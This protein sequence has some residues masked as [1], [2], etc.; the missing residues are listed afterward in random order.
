MKEIRLNQGDLAYVQCFDERRTGWYQKLRLCKVEGEEKGQVRYLKIY[1]Y[2]HLNGIST[3][4]LFKPSTLEEPDENSSNI[5]TKV[6]RGG[7]NVAKFISEGFFETKNNIEFLEII[8]VEEEIIKL[9]WELNNLRDKH[10][11]LQLKYGLVVK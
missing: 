4:S 9:E 7:E 2:N 8:E 3:M 1:P 5:I 6:I 11:A 10:Y